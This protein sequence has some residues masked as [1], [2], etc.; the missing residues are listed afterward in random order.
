LRPRTW[1]IDGELRGPAELALLK[2]VGLVQ[3]LCAGVDHIPF[4][5]LPEDVTVASNAGA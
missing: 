5:R 4:D 2:S 3:L 1:S